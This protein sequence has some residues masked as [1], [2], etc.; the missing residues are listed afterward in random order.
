LLLTLALTPSPLTSLLL[1]VEGVPVVAVV[2]RV[3]LELLRELLV[4]GHLPKPF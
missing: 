1:L 4:V 2:V 3:D